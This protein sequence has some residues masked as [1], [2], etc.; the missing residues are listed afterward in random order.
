MDKDW[1]SVGGS[2]M[3]NNCKLNAF[4]RICLLLDSSFSELTMMGI[5]L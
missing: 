5:L 2:A 1:A 3:E 4:K